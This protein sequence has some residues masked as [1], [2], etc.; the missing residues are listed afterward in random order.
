M[1]KEIIIFIIDCGIIIICGS[2]GA[3]IGTALGGLY[4]F[5]KKD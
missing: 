1:I 4:E 2:V 3:I 5:F